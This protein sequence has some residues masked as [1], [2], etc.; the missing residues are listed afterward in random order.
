MKQEYTYIIPMDFS[1]YIEN[2]IKHPKN[3]KFSWLMSSETNTEYYMIYHRDPDTSCERLVLNLEYKD[4][5]MI[6]CITNWKLVHVP[7]SQIDIEK[8]NKLCKEDKYF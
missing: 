3:F 4:N 5:F 1:S 2:I 7:S 8:L 6:D